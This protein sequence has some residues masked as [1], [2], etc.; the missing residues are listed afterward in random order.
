MRKHTKRRSA[1]KFPP[2]DV[3]PR[4]IVYAGSSPSARFG[5]MVV[6]DLPNEEQLE[7]S[8]QAKAEGAT[9][10]KKRFVYEEI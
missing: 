5:V 4:R 2:S 8:D 3:D 1:K 7:L 10:P 6:R 9:Y